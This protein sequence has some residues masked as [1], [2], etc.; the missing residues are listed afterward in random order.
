MYEYFLYY[1]QHTILEQIPIPEIE[2]ERVY[3]HDMIFEFWNPDPYNRKP[4][5]E[6]YIFIILI[7]ENIKFNPSEKSAMIYLKYL[8]PFTEYSFAQDDKGIFYI[9][10]VS[11]KEGNYHFEINNNISEYNDVTF[12]TLSCGSYYDFVIGKGY[13][14]QKMNYILYSRYALFRIKA[15]TNNY[16]GLI[17]SY[18]I[19]LTEHELEIV[20]D[21]ENR[22]KEIFFNAK[23]RL[24]EWN[25]IEECDHYEVYLFKGFLDNNVT[26]CFFIGKIQKIRI[27]V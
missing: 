19:N 25:S 6:Y 1:G 12:R 20:D 16:N 5:V 9:D 21:L 7:K 22:K 10:K 11:K 2:K 8:I 15:T 17:V 26:S 24:I 23:H 27:S 4:N 13:Y 14:S 18:G 3:D